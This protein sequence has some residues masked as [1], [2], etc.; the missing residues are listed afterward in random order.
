MKQVRKYSLIKY[1]PIPS[2]REII[3]RKTFRTIAGLWLLL[4]RQQMYKITVEKLIWYVNTHMITYVQD[5]YN[6]TMAK[7]MEL[8]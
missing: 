7:Y 3:Q 8:K 4:Y 2:T 5:P 1:E 6:W